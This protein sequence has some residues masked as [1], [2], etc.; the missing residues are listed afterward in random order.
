MKVKIKKINRTS[1][2]YLKVTLQRLSLINDF[3]LSFLISLMKSKFNSINVS[4]KQYKIFKNLNDRYLALDIYERYTDWFKINGFTL[5]EYE[6]AYLET[7]KGEFEKTEN[8]LR[9]QRQT[10][11]NPAHKI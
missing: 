5:D 9:F 3:E 10:I 6:A 2:V 1:V 4:E 8:F 7:Y 11:N